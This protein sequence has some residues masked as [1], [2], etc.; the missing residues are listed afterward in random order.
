MLEKWETG[1]DNGAYVYF[2]FMNLS[3]TFDA[4]SHDLMLATLKAYGFS[5]NA[6]NLMHSY[7]K[8]R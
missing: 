4:I 8:D 7:L 6:L 3:K 2:L 5:I 1:I